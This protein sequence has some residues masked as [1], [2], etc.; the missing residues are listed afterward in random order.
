ML[1]STPEMCDSCPLLL[2]DGAST[3]GQWRNAWLFLGL[4][5]RGL[6]SR[7]ERNRSHALL[8]M[9]FATNQWLC[10]IRPRHVQQGKLIATVVSGDV[11]G[12]QLLFSPN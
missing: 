7:V 3:Q 6:G 11:C 5:F 12:E 9:A 10:K 1:L 2:G 8:L 4:G